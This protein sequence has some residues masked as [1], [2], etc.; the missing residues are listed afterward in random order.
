MSLK[1][2]MNIFDLDQGYRRYLKH[3][4]EIHVTI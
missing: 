1:A 4:R 3:K 2:E